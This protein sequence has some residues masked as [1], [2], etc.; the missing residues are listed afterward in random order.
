MT[1]WSRSSSPHNPNPNPIPNPN[2]N[3]NPNLYAEYQA[4][5][6]AGIDFSA[7]S[8]YELF[9]ARSDPWHMRNLHAT[10]DARLKAALHA[11]LHA[12]YGCKGETCP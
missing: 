3:P 12:W 1:P 4:G 10:A 9:D 2:P 8:F 5:P 11:E 6:F 7:P